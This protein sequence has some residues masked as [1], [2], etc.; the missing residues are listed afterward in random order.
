VVRGREAVKA[1][2]GDPLPHGYS[3]RVT[4]RED[5]EA[6]HVELLDSAHTVQ[7]TRINNKVNWRAS[8]PLSPTIEILARW[9]EYNFLSDEGW[10]CNDCPVNG[11]T[12]ESAMA[13]ISAYA[14][15]GHKFTRTA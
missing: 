14:A 15:P 4:F 12:I 1:R 8:G 11:T 5:G 2:K 9:M 7:A 13:H 6:T 10:Q 3:T